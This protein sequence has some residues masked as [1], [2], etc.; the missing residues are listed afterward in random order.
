MNREQKFVLLADDDMVVAEI[1]THTLSQHDPGLQI[2]HVR[3]GVEALDF[4]YCR[5]RYEHREPVNP[6]VI[7]LD[8]KMPR[9]DGLE[10]LRQV[11]NDDNLKSTPVVMLTSSQHESDIRDC[12]QAGANAYVVKPV[13]FRTFSAVLQQIDTFWMRINQPAPDRHPATPSAWKRS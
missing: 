6:T 5:E 1:V 13:E 8:V 12:Y 4:L 9:L 3:D 11:K 7:L 2:V 10:V